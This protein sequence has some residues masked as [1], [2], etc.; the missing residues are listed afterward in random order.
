MRGY[1]IKVTKT[2]TYKTSYV[3]KVRTRVRVH[4]WDPFAWVY[5]DVFVMKTKTYKV[6]QTFYTYTDPHT[7]CKRDFVPPRPHL[8]QVA[9]IHT[10][11]AYV[12][13]AGEYFSDPDKWLA[14]TAGI[15]F[16]LV[17]PGGLLKVCYPN[18]NTATIATNMPKDPNIK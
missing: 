4:W 14:K 11:A 1:Y 2:Y 18:G 15:P 5:K 16:Y 6:T 10:H 9:F 17:T 8:N 7:V 12:S 13:E 3:E